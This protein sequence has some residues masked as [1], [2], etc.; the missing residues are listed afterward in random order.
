MHARQPISSRLRTSKDR[1]RIAGGAVHNAAPRLHTAAGGTRRRAT[2]TP[3]GL[4]ALRVWP[5]ASQASPVGASLAKAGPAHRTHA[6]RDV[7]AQQQLACHPTE[8][9]CVRRQSTHNIIRTLQDRHEMGCWVTHSR[10]TSQA[11]RPTTPTGPGRPA[12]GPGVLRQAS[13]LWG[14]SHPSTRA[15]AAHAP[16]APRIACPNAAP[17]GVAGAHPCFGGWG[18][19]EAKLKRLP[20]C[21]AGRQAKSRGGVHP[22][23]AVLG[24]RGGCEWRP[25]W[26][27]WKCQAASRQRRALCCWSGSRSLGQR[28]GPAA[29]RTHTRTYIHSS[30]KSTGLSI[31]RDGR[32][33]CWLAL[34]SKTCPQC[35]LARQAALPIACAA[36]AC[37][38]ASGAHCRAW[39]RVGE[40]ARAAPPSLAQLSL[41]RRPAA[42]WPLPALLAPRRPLPPWQLKIPLARPPVTPCRPARHAPRRRRQR[43]APSRLRPR[44]HRP[45][46]AAALAPER[47]RQRPHAPRGRAP[48]Q[49]PSRKSHCSAPSGP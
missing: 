42:R 26:C 25:G 24:V 36:A 27:L 14:S 43:R 7:T 45:P 38:A 8:S 15:W 20:R 39:Q 9:E 44:R 17:A 40:V 30:S 28:Q 22:A 4:A 35:T 18:V 29:R 1:H 2:S 46:C 37:T 6:R 41:R 11:P 16:R 13:A 21:S 3:H 12:G 31:R 33:I 49:S 5:G 32:A 10:H 19:A 47:R 48:L 23:A 34:F